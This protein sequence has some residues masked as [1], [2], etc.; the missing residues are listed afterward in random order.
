M[1]AHT[2]RLHISPLTPESLATILRPPFSDHVTDISFHTLVAFPENSYGFV[3]LPVA[4]AE[5]FKKKIHG[6]V[7]RGV[8]MKIE[9]ARAK[10]SEEEELKNDGGGEKK[11]KR[12]SKKSK[13]AG[14]RE[15]GVLPGIE[16]EAGRKVRRGWT[17]SDGGD[18]KDAKNRKDL[19]VSKKHHKTYKAASTTG[20]EECLFKTQLPP[21]ARAVDESA[22]ETAGKVKKRKRGKSNGEIVVHE[23]AHTEKHATFLRETPNGAKRRT[24]SEF[25]EGKGWLDNEGNVVDEG[26]AK[27]TR[28]A[29]K[30]KADLKK[31]EQLKPESE[32]G[33]DA[34]SSSGPSS[35]EEIESENNEDL[36]EDSQNIGSLASSTNPKGLGISRTV[37]RLSITRSSATPPPPPS[38]DEP[39]PTL[40]SPEPHP[41]ETLF[42]RPSA[43]ASQTPK[44][45][46]LLEVSTSFSFDLDTQDAENRLSIPQTPFTQ[47]DIRQRRQRS[48]AP[49]PD[50][51]APGK[52]FGNVWGGPESSDIAS[53]DDD[54]QTNEDGTKLEELAKGTPP[55]EGE[56]S[57]FA[58]WF[59]EHR[60]ENNRAWKRRRREA[61]KG[62][63]QAENRKRKGD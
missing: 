31:P 52:T 3:T 37:E 19:I 2:K 23:F 54:E 49:T 7:L 47:Q 39:I 56:E 26:P 53:E 14:G 55:K 16:L 50:T 42:K 41:L 15:E 63:R 57:E 60:G 18:R 6:C 25:V 29:S 22:E 24:A 13:Q 35:S 46:P 5:K 9:E 33:D 45:K 20:K 27:R 51:A 1:L 12:S 44:G 58:K 32:D 48:A 8:K 38:S 61:I 59:Y 21:N 43:A 34:T 40:K 62:K 4:E 17:E 11:P 30:A 36:S 10:Q 28:R